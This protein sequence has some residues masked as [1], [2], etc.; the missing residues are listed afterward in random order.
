MFAQYVWPYPPLP[1]FFAVCVVSTTIQAFFI[2]RKLKI[3]FIFP[4]LGV[5]NL[6]Y[7]YFY[8]SHASAIPG[9]LF[10]EIYIFFT[11]ALPG[12]AVL[13]GTAF[14]GCIVL[15]WRLCI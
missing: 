6:V 14:G 2:K 8:A 4:F 10:S 11:Y 5:L 13:G 9:V 12:I 1:V 15:L 7:A 3:R